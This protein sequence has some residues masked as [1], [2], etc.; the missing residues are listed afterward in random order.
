MIKSRRARRENNILTALP[1]LIADALNKIWL[2]A[3]TFSA[4]GQQRGRARDLLDADF[5]C[6]QAKS[7]DTVQERSK[8]YYTQTTANRNR[9]EEEEEKEVH[10]H[11]F[12]STVEHRVQSLSH[13]SSLTS[14]SPR[15][16]HAEA[17]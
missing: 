9:E 8:K 13:C 7:D 16:S 6:Q 1:S 11:G 12:F 17:A 15:S 5:Y 4:K 10:A 14:S 2:S 3:R